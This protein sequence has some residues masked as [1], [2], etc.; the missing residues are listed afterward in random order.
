[1]PAPGN[2]AVTPHTPPSASREPSPAAADLLSQLAG[3]LS[4]GEFVTVLTA[5]PGRPACLTVTTR[6]AGV[7]A[8]IYAERG[9]YW[10]GWAERIA[11]TSHPY[12]AAA[13]ITAALLPT[14]ASDA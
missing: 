6:R 4:P 8:G 5:G 1:M 10:W 12:T 2:T 9:W 7:T 13:T 3:V 11:P 14:G